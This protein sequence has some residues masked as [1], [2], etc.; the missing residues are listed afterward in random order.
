VTDCTFRLSK[1]EPETAGAS[2]QVLHEVLELLRGVSRRSAL[3]RIAWFLLRSRD[4][5]PPISGGQGVF[6]FLIP[7]GDIADHIGLSLETVS[8]GLTELR[9]KNVIDMPNRNA[10]RFKDVAQLAMIAQS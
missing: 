5:L 7:R 4:H 1:P 6:K 9:A 2:E 8:R 10:I 3:S